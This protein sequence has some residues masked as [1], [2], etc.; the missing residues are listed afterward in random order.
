MKIGLAYDLRSQYRDIGYSEDEIAGFDI[1]ETVEAVESAV[2]S[3]GHDA[4]RI[5]NVFDLVGKLA[6]GERWDMVF[7]MAIGL[8]GR[9]REQQVPAILES[10]NIAYTFS[11]P[12]SLALA[13]DKA[14]AKALVRNA[15]VATSDFIVV[16]SP[17]ELDD[18]AWQERFEAAFPKN[19]FILFKRKGGNDEIEHPYPLFVKPLA[20]RRG[21]GVSARSIVRNDID[22]KR[23]ITNVCFTCNQPVI[24]ER[25]L[26]GREFAVGMFG[27]GESARVAGMVETVYESS[28]AGKVEFAKVKDR[29]I[30]SRA[31]SAALEA[32]KTLECRDAGVV[33]LRED[34]SGRLQFIEINAIPCFHPAN[35]ALPNICLMNKAGYAGFISA[36]IEA[37]IERTVVKKA[38]SPFSFKSGP[39]ETGKVKRTGWRS[40]T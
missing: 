4:A 40:F 26:P 12:R 34:A 39:A 8:H 32:W 38:V 16:R 37:A 6:S 27:T 21:K 15:G 22:L 25:Y 3:L 24:V 1:D 33:E 19:P 30:I 17:D 23:Q 11:D 14:I 35:G 18:A 36:V 13:T 31:S 29:E 10:H 7:N 2:S 28:S 20:E 9:N 5:G